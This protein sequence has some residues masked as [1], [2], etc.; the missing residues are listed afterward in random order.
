MAIRTPQPFFDSVAGDR[1]YSSA[2]FR[3]IF[4]RAA[5]NGI[6]KGD[7]DELQVVARIPAEMAVEVGLGSAFI[8]GGWI[9]VYSSPE[10]LSITTANPLNPRI[11]R[12]VIRLD[13]TAR[14]ISLGVKAGTPAVVPVPPSL[15]RSASVWELSLAQVLVGAA[16]AQVASDDITDE[17]HDPAVCGVAASPSSV[18]QVDGIPALQADVLANRPSATIED[19]RI[20]VETDGRRKL[21]RSTGSAWEEIGQARV[22]ARVRRNA[23][24]AL[25]A[26]ATAAVS[27][28]TVGWDNGGLFDL[29]DPTRLTAPE[30]GIYTISG[31]AKVSGSFAHSY[32]LRVNGST[33]IARVQQAA[34]SLDGQMVATTW[35]MSAGD[36]VELI[37]HNG[38]TGG[39]TIDTENPW[40]P[41]LV[42]T[43]VG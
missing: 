20:F 12:V 31:H 22:S 6:V 17:R 15:E 43:R 1:I 23:S 41:S 19:G 42:M 37:I 26:S 21:W 29:G 4:S 10:V 18:R 39:E 3:R 28:T 13:S 32:A 36:Y 27:F 8:E 25:G 35:Q 7:E 38:S 14:T 9:Q 30:S 24:Q 16:A 11:D 40:C 2:D 5:Q 33:I 34:T